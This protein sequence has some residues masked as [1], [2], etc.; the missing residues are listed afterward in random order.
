MDEIRQEIAALRQEVAQLRQELDAAN[1]WA[2]GIHRALVDVLPFL[3]RGHPEAAK[4]GK[5]LKY[6]ADRYEELQEHPDRA[7]RDAG[8]S[9][10]GYEAQKS[11]YRQL[12]LL[13]VWPGVD[14]HEQALEALARAG[15]SGP[16]PTSSRGAPGR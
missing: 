12:A 7:D 14:P 2:C 10:A 11:L 16:D 9:W 8:E 3:L 1:D 5:L 6:S 15:W 4:V 13:G